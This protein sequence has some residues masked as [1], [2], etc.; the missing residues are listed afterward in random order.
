MQNKIFLNI[1]FVSAPEARSQR[2][3]RHS[4]DSVVSVTHLELVR[5]CFRK[6]KHVLVTTLEAEA[7]LWLAEGQK[8][9]GKK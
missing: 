9:K 2:E 8:V 6:V 4:C 7:Q 5:G 3:L 1:F